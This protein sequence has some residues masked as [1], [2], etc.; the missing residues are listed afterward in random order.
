M[1]YKVVPIAAEIAR[2]V[3]EKM[4]SPQYGH[5]AHA[6]TAK[7]YGP[8]RVC[9]EKFVAGAEERILFTY[10]AFENLSPLPLPGPVFIH[11]REC[12][13]FAANEFPPAL[14]DLPLL[15]EAY[16]AE[17]V[18]IAREALRPAEIDRQIGALFARE[19]VGF[20]NLRNAEAGCFVARVERA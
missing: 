8:C 3:R 10:N 17:S 18:L 4:K 12:R 16:G 13:A 2:A 1:Q 5:P 19:S 15:F 11:R 20:I 14:R 7:G 6:E 9:L